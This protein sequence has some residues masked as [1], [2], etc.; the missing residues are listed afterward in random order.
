MLDK[1]CIFG[2]GS[3][4]CIGWI[5]DSGYTPGQYILDMSAQTQSVELLLKSEIEK[6]ELIYS[7][8]LL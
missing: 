1:L 5:V 3:G 7:I 4:I 8:R 6:D 2:K